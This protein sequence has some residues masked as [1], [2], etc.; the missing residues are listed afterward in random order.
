MRTIIADDHAIMR[1]GLKQLLSTVD[2]LIVSGEAADAEAVHR[3]L[4]ENSADLLILD[5]GMPGVSGFQFIAHLRTVWPGLRVLV[6]TA[7]V[8][9]RSVR[10]AFS[11]GASG[12]LTKSGDPS[13]LVAAIDAIRKGNLYVAEEVRFAVDHHDGPNEI[14]E[15]IAAI[16]SP[17][18]LTRRERQILAMI[19]H[20]ATNRDI[21]SRL[22][23][24]PLTARKHREN[25]MRKLD[26]HNGAELTAYAVRLGLPAG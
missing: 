13:E 9:P 18:A 10:A 14:P 3:L 12:Y 8:E 11:A 20:G 23:I 1:E 5:L 6:L 24:S 19:P 21:A 7:N 26:L 22:G 17:V 4:N 25:L 16:V 2:D 15:P